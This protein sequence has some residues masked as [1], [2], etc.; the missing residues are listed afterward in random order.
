F[1]PGGAPR[2]RA[3]DET[4]PPLLSRAEIAAARRGDRATGCTG[5]LA[6]QLLVCPAGMPA[7][8][9]GGP[10]GAP[11]GNSSPR[12]TPAPSARPPPPPAPR[13]ARARRA[14]RPPP[15]PA[16]PRGARPPRRAPRRRP[17]PRR[18]ARRDRRP[19]RRLQRAP[20]RHRRADAPEPRLH[21]RPGPRAEE[22]R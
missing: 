21:G 3:Y 13:R 2:L 11:A 4:R 1:G 12:A 20:R 18:L 9:P 15:Q 17:H 14:P 10:W 5:A 16:P 19:R 7:E 8:G 6:G 22:P